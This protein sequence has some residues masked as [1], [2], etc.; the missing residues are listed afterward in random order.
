MKTLPHSLLFAQLFLSL[1]VAPD[2]KAQMGVWTAL[3]NQA[4]VQINT[5]FLLSDGTVLGNQFDFGTG[6]GGAW[7][8]LTPDI[9]G[10]YVNGTWSQLASMHDTRLFFASQ[11]LTNGQFFVAGGEFGSGGSSAETYDPLSNVWSLVNQ[12]PPEGLGDA[13]SM[14]L[15]DSR[16]LVGPANG[17][18]QTVIY[19][20]VARTATAGPSAFGGQ[21]EASW[22]KLPDNSIL[23]V[24][25]N[26]TLSERFVPSLNR[27]VSD[28]NVPVALYSGGEIGAALLL[29]NG[30]AFFLGCS[31]HTALY[32]PT[33]T[34]NSGTWAA[35]PDIPNRLIPAD[36]PAAMLVNGRLL[37]AVTDQTNTF[38]Y[39]YDPT[40]N[41]FTQVNGPTGS[42]FPGATDYLRMLDL[43]DGTV[44]FG[45]NATQLYVY[46][47][48]GSALTSGKPTI[49]SIS[50]NPD[51]SY[52]L[53]GL[54]LNGISAG[55]AY[56]DDAQ[57][58]SNYPL[59]RMTNKPTGNVYYARTYNWSSTGVRT[60][61]NIVTTE[62]S[63]PTYVP[64]GTYSLVAV[65]NGIASDPISFSVAPVLSIA[66][67]GSNVI[68]SWPALVTGWTL[69][70]NDNLTTGVWGD[71]SG[72]IVN[73]AASITPSSGTLFFRLTTP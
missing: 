42:A 60:G 72:T 9:H 48:A 36:A 33:G 47:P 65:A 21:N 45:Y 62:F 32:T 1:V 34:T 68:V 28:A 44:L 16:V 30:K 71:Y 29:P 19:N 69:Q 31:G 27:W 39:E 3:A 50:I 5:M 13:I 43:P 73:N 67:S 6:H 41:N 35:G 10:S 51:R 54:L 53:K 11:L 70:T 23:T 25:E 46:Q 4:P 66:H 40:A 49:S 18:G 15:P 14:L 38:F 24:D 57:M 22:V 2:L 59:V 58:D 55:A 8:R 17:S 7:Y 26:S 20:L 63:I 12:A 52:Q 61:T 56:G 64:T 37:C